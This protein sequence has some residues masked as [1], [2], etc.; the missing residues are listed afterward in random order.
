ML[1]VLRS[2]EIRWKGR[3]FGVV[4]LVEVGCGR[5]LIP[6]HRP[7]LPA[8]GLCLCPQWPRLDTQHSVQAMTWRLC[9]AEFE[10]CQFPD[11]AELDQS[12]FLKPSPY[13]PELLPAVFAHLS[14]LGTCQVSCNGGMRY[15]IPWQVVG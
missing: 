13:R 1:P 9:R 10:G 3:W 7:E 5:R 6:G 4:C 15:P 2:Y 12:D 8:A 11:R 14:N